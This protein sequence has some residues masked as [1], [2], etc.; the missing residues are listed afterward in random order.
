MGNAARWMLLASRLLGLK[1]EGED[2]GLLKSM[3]VGE[4]LE[5]KGVDGMNVWKMVMGKDM[6]EGEGE[7]R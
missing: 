2:A 7:V 4:P 1:A 6:L 5:R 3:D